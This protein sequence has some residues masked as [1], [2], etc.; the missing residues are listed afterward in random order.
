MKA[1]V[2]LYGGSDATTCTIEVEY[3]NLTDTELYQVADCLGS[4]PSVQALIGN[5]TPNKVMSLQKQ[6]ITMVERP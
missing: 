6:N 2:T 4:L 5:S 3:V 1:L